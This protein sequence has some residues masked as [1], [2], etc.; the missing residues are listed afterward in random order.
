MIA[1][2]RDM[3]LVGDVKFI[4]NGGEFCQCRDGLKSVV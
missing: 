1:L 2:D 4:K 3:I